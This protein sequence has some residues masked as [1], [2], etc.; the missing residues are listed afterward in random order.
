MMAGEELCHRWR[1]ID[2]VG[3]HRFDETYIIRNALQMRQPFSDRRTTRPTSREPDACGHD[4]LLLIR[5]HGRDA[6]AS[7]H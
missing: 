3:V 5:S 2:L 7:S 6:L 1:M 4:Q